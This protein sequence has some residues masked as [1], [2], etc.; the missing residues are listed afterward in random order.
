LCTGQAII[1]AVNSVSP[2]V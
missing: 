2:S 1:K